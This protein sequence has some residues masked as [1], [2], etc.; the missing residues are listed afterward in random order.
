MTVN[1]DL[2]KQ[3]VAQFHSQLDA[4]QYA[5]LYASADPELHNITAQDDFTKLL[6][7]VHSKL[8]DVK[9]SNLRTWNTNWSTGQGT[10]VTLT[11]D[12]TFS[13]GSG[14]EQF[15]WHISDKRALLY[16]YHINS[17]DLIEK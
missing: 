13:T 3:G 7:A 15:V 6:A 8:G 10:I 1:T 11:Y 17:A 2:A 12:T 16:G 4:E 9:Q 5:A 14:T